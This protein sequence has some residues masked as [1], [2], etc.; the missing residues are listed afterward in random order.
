MYCA[1][2]IRILRKSPSS[3]L[4]LL[5]ASAGSLLSHPKA[6]RA[7]ADGF[8]FTWSPPASCPDAA[9]VR[10]EIES[11]LHG[12]IALASDQKLVVH[13]TVTEPRAQEPWHVDIDTDDGHLQA[14]R[15]Y[16]A[17]R[18]DELAEKTALFVAILI[19]SVVN[20]AGVPS[21]QADAEK[22]SAPSASTIEAAPA[23]PDRAAP[24]LDEAEASPPS[25]GAGLTVGAV[26]GYLPHWS[27]GVGVYGVVGWNALR[28]QVGGQAS[29]PARRTVDEAGTQ[30]A[31]FQAFSGGIDLCIEAAAGTVRLGPCAGVD[32]VFLKG[33]GF[34]PG[35]VSRT[36]TATFAAISIGGALRW[37][38]SARLSFPLQLEVLVP[39]AHP[40]FVFTG[41]A[42]TSVHKPAAIGGSATLGAEIHF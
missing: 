41:T 20:R 27:P 34:G 14:R 42:G 25:F 4:V 24:T 40:E 33:T 36:D 37:V 2:G 26:G 1:S 38:A 8:Q 18:C 23:G 12:P 9:G 22:P 17:A 29:L 3:L 21:R 5:A 32:L 31:D 15:S 13:A 35:V 39:L 28:A 30:G 10:A 11:I 16:D 19:D 6:A 7:E